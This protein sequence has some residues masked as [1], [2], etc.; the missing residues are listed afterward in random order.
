[1]QIALLEEGLHCAKMGFNKRF[2]ALRDVK[3]A[4]CRRLRDRYRALA[5][6]NHEL[7][8]DEPLAAPAMQLDEEP[9]R[10]DE[11]SED[12]IQAFLVARDAED[13][14]AKAA[15]AGGGGGGFGGF[16]SGA[17]KPVAGASAQVGVGVATGAPAG[18]GRGSGRIVETV[19]EAVARVTANTPL[20]P[21]EQ[22]E[23]TLRARQLV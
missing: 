17:D 8:L 11:V 18:G 22:A 2:L 13:A 23:K 14:S 16:G 5:A 1:M 21:L 20:T 4:A 12:E 9:E 10:R 6:V 15:A 7:E 3:R 19:A